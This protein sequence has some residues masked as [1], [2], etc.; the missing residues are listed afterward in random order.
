LCPI[1]VILKGIL[2]L[3]DREVYTRLM[4]GNYSDSDRSDKL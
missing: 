4:K 2:N 3:S 1:I